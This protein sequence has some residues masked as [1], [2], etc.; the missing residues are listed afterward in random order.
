LISEGIGWDS[1]Y[2]VFGT[3]IREVGTLPIIIASLSGILGLI[4]VIVSL[5]KPNPF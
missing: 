1:Q 3:A 5:R 4:L 2:G